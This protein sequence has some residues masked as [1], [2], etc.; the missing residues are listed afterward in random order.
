MEMRTLRSPEQPEAYRSLWPGLSALLFLL[1]AGGGGLL[2]GDEPLSTHLDSRS[3]PPTFAHLFG[4]DW[5][6]RD[7]FNRTVKGLGLSMAVGFLGAVSSSLI[8]AVVGLLAAT[9][10]RAADRFLSWL[11]DLF[12]SVP[13]L[14]TLILIAFVCGGGLKGI[15]IGIACTHWPSLAR[16]V[17]AEMKQLRSSEYIL[18]SRRLGKSRLW[19]ARHHLLPHLVPQL[20]VGMLLMFPHA[21]LHEAAVTFIGLGMSPHQPAIG[22]ILSESMRYLST[23]MW[24]LAFFPGLCLLLMVRAFD[25]FGGMIQKL[26]GSS[27]HHD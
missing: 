22:I 21:I 1:L 18:V 9:M 15:V 14:V 19:I 16:V 26:A 13:N 6:G 8:A 3:L 2:L 7:M 12:L 20:L 27:G 24:W 10:G 4:T 23:G 5:L 11:T 25:T 17:R